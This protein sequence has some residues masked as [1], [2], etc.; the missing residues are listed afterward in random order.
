MKKKKIIIIEFIGF[1]IF[2]HLSI[3]N[4]IFLFLENT[5]SIAIL[6]YP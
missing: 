4:T 2:G 5:V 3:Y 1:L 6:K